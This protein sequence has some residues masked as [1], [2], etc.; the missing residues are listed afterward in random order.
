M[1]VPPS[2]PPSK[3]YNP[4]LGKHHPVTIARN[5]NCHL[6]SLC[7]SLLRTHAGRLTGGNTLLPLAK[8]Q[9]MQVL[10]LK[11]HKHFFA[12]LLQAFRIKCLLQICRRHSCQG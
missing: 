6:H 1:H 10:M 5:P 4:P 12:Q 11:G 7:H 2:E 9:P 3:T 8:R